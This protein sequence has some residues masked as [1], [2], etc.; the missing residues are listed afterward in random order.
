MTDDVFAHGFAMITLNPAGGPAL[1]E[2]FDDSTASQPRY[3]EQIFGTRVS[4]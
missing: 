2:Y 1:V 3:S 4:A